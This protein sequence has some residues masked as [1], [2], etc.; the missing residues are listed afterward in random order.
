MNPSKFKVPIRFPQKDR[1]VWKDFLQLSAEHK[2]IDMGLGCTN[3]PLPTY[4]NDILVEVV[5]RNDVKLNQYARGFG[6]IRLV[7]ALSKFY[8][9]LTGITYDPMTE[10]LVTAG[11]S[12]ALYLSIQGFI[13]TNDEVIIIEPYFDSYEPVVK[14]C[15]G[16]SKFIALKPMENVDNLNATDWILDFDE[17]EKMF[18]NKT[19][20]IMLNTPNNPLGK[21]FTQNE[22]EKIAELCIKWD[23]ICVSDEVYEW[24]VY[25]NQKHIRICTIPGMAERT[26]TIGSVGK[27]F[28]VTG[29]KTGWAYAPANIIK[30]LQMVHQNVIYSCVTVVQEAIAILLENEIDKLDTP[31]SYFL[32]LQAQ[33][34]QKRDYAL[35]IL[36]KA[37]M[38]V[39]RPNGGFFM[40]ANW[41]ALAGDV[42]LTPQNY[43]EERDY[44]FAK[45]LA[46]NIGLL[47][48]PSSVFYSHDHKYIGEDY[49]RF[50]FF[51]TD[52]T[53]KNAENVLKKWRNF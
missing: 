41:T 29:W 24:L 44:L 27:S 7:N 16:I 43:D 17:F 5:S 34:V 50:C 30:R 38:K 20:M 47:G 26:I 13:D 9:K 19:K 31:D 25:D 10:F 48:I 42:D 23:V 33:L 21:V 35:E 49:V 46:K 4:I 18:N 3:E 53:L 37:G 39:T 22:L 45:W 6:H 36:E 40:L 8:A 14:I 11:A 51:K 15:G 12:E 28:S 2:C 32:S 1:N 52:E